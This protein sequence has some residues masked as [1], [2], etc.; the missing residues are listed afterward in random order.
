MT[1]ISYYSYFKYYLDGE[2]K[3]VVNIFP[4]KKDL[5]IA[6]M[7]RVQS[8]PPHVYLQRVSQRRP[9]VPESSH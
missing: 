5:V 7:C 3:I 1:I 2:M 9:Y 6:W 4:C 8:N